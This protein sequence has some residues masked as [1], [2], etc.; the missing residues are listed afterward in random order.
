M[1]TWGSR[2]PMWLSFRK[3]VV[4][5]AVAAWPGI[6][7]AATSRGGQLPDLWAPASSS[8]RGA[9][10]RGEDA[11]SC[12]HGLRCVKAWP[13]AASQSESLR[14]PSPNGTVRVCVLQVGGRWRESDRGGW[15]GAQTRVGLYFEVTEEPVRVLI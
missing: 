10:A 8:V 15:R 6:R 4:W 3:C 11:M 1:H 9:Q 12:L 2:N 13:G 7:S 14:S 5:W